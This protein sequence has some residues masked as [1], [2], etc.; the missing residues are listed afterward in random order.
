M[1]RQAGFVRLRELLIE[2]PS[3]VL[4][5][6]MDVPDFDCILVSVGRPKS[7]SSIYLTYKNPVPLIRVHLSL[8]LLV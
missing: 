5:G 2:E 8:V 1:L 3:K 7:D 6:G 4:N